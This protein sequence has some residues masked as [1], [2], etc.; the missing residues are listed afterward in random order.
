M[1]IKYIFMRVG[2]L[3]IFSEISIRTLF[4]FLKLDYFFLIIVEFLEFLYV[5][6]A[7]PVTDMRFAD[8]FL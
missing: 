7:S 3:Y 6:D 4:L 8:I 5:L 1:L 2:H